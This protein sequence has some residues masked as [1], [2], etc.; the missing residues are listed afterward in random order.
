M[1]VGFSNN[2]VKKTESSDTPIKTEPVTTVAKT[3]IKTENDNRIYS[4]P[5]TKGKVCIYYIYIYF[6]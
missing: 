5:C 6:F 2:I 1:L 3:N 4:S